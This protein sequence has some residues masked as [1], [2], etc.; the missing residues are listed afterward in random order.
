MNP[1]GRLL[2]AAMHQLPSGV[3]FSVSALWYGDESTDYNV[4]LRRGQSANEE[5][6]GQT[7]VTSHENAPP[8][9]PDGW[10]V[11]ASPVIMHSATGPKCLL[12]QGSAQKLSITGFCALGSTPAAAVEVA[13]Q[14]FLAHNGNLRK[15]FACDRDRAH[16]DTSGDMKVSHNKGRL[17]HSALR[18]AQFRNRE[19][20]A[21][22]RAEDASVRRCHRLI[23]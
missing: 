19:A 22:V 16:Y 1:T 14:S 5:S 13:V 18:H 3:A 7:L 11:P 8:A 21:A 4:R 23:S 17:T 9:A 12:A 10:C 6:L 2:T 20:C 15:V